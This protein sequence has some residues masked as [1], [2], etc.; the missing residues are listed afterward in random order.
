M[1]AEHGLVGHV[2]AIRRPILGAWALLL[3]SFAG[4]QP[5]PAPVGPVDHRGRAI[6]VRD[7][8]ELLQRVLQSNDG[9]G[10]LRTVHDVTLEL[11][12]GGQRSEKRTFR[13]VLAV[14]R[15]GHFRLAIL[16][17]V[18]MKLVDL[19]YMAGKTKVIHVAPELARSSRL[20]AILDSIAADIAAIYRLDPQL[21]PSRRRLEE[22]VS[23][24]SGRAP[25]YELKEFRRDELARQLTIFAATLAVARA[26][27]SDERG[28]SRTIVFGDYETHGKVLVP[29]SIHVAN[30]GRAFYWLA[31]RVESVD[32]DVKL[33]DHLFVAE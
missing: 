17:P 25:L 12:L 2:A 8:D 16:G 10:T 9:Y 27:V 20:P 15:P 21:Y 28:D 3:T 33:D 29:R 13:G 6:A 26:E 31:I 19:L 30:E 24:A 23:Y 7:A 32:V 4:C 11:V 22:S 1:R 18:G 5:P 14:R